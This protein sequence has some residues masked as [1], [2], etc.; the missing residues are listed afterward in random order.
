M[1][2]NRNS[3]IASVLYWIGVIA[4][5]LSVISG[6]VIL[7]TVSVVT[8]LTTVISGFVYGFLLLGFSEI[9]KLLLTGNLEKQNLNQKLDQLIT[10]QKEMSTAQ[11][12]Q[13]PPVL[14]PKS[15]VEPAPPAEAEPPRKP[16]NPQEFLETLRPL[17]N[18]KEIRAALESN[19]SLFDSNTYQTIITEVDRLVAMGRLY[20]DMKQ[21]I[22]VYLS[23]VLS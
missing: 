20:G 11:T 3:A 19:R 8:G 23:K 15:K 17:S 13:Q 22:L 18:G 16:K 12:A 5:I 1:D 9:L 21:D 10:L 4:I 6:L 7:T 14:S 2:N